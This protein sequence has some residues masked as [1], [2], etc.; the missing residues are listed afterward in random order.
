MTLQIDQT[1]SQLILLEG[2]NTKNLSNNQ[3]TNK[4]LAKPSRLQASEAAN[5][6]MLHTK[7]GTLLCYVRLSIASILSSTSESPGYPL[8]QRLPPYSTKEERRS[9]ETAHKLKHPEAAMLLAEQ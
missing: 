7:G 1:P 6:T 5:N 4:K 2:L 8:K 3:T 9:T